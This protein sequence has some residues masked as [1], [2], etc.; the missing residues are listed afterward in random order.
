MFHHHQFPNGLTLL[1]ET[2]PHRKS[3]TLL[4]LCPAGS[5]NDPPRK[6]GL[7]ALVCEMMLRGAGPRGNRDFLEAMDALGIHRS[8]AVYPFGMEF[9]GSLLA[10]N[11][12]GAVHL[13]ADMIRAPRFSPEEWE[14][15]RQT[16]LQEA[17]DEDPA[18]YLMKCLKEHFYGT[19]WGHD[20]DGKRED[21]EKIRWEEVVSHYRKWIRPNGMVL[22]AAGNFE[23][24]QLRRVVEE[25]Y[26]D[27]TPIDVP[28]LEAPQLH[29]EPFHKSWD[30]E[31]T[32]LG[33]A[34]ETLPFAH[35]DRLTAWAGF[36]VLGDGMSGRFYNEIRE[37]RGLCYSVEASCHSLKEKGGVFSLMATRPKKAA[38]ALDLLLTEVARLGDGIS[39][40]EL[41]ALKARSQSSLVRLRESSSAWCQRMVQDWYYLERVRSPE[42]IL[43][44]VENLSLDS[45]NDYLANHPVS[46]IL[47]ATCG[48]R[49]VSR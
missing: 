38:Q 43:R 10:E 24:E 32:H 45:I 41:A 1:A 47:I 13:Y 49:A 39:C 18:E 27:W 6:E 14:A 37:K 8:E 23:W 4:H 36:S 20:A 33:L 9:Q 35:P 44:Q 42:E 26:G 22:A 46:P 11:W 2:Y 19:V 31:Q 48:S 29:W 34:W 3:F 40:E 15:A 12:E 28:P 7:T 17:V 25:R 16:Q 5:A 21:L 30:S